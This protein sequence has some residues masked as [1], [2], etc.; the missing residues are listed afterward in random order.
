M[1][2]GKMAIKMNTDSSMNHYDHFTIIDSVFSEFQAYLKNVYNF[3]KLYVSLV[4]A[5]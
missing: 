5:Y 3:K 2:N 1:N 4:F